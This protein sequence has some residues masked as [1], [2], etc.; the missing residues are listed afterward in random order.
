MTEFDRKRI[1]VLLVQLADVFNHKF[2]AESAKGYLKALDD[3]PVATVERAIARCLKACRR[4]PPPAEIRE[5]ARPEGP[6]I[7]LRDRRA[8]SG[9]SDAVVTRAQMAA[10]LRAVA[11]RCA[12]TLAA[13]FL[14][15]AR[16]MDAGAGAVGDAVAVMTGAVGRDPGEEG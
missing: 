3:M 1:G 12:P 15:L 6:P 10:T 11:P 7:P 2:S 8:L 4:F 5:H 9:P 14:R 13:G 16:N